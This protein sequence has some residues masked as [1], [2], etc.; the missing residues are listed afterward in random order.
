MGQNRHPLPAIIVP[1]QNFPSFRHRRHHLHRWENVQV[2]PEP[3]ILTNNFKFALF[4]R[5]IQL[6]PTKILIGVKRPS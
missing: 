5:Q 3:E 4:P 1:D 6:H 2:Q